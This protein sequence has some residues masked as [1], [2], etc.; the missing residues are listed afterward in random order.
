MANS[1]SQALKEAQDKQ[2]ESKVNRRASKA[3]QDLEGH[4]HVIRS[5]SESPV[6][7]AFNQVQKKSRL[8][9]VN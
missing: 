5:G 1:L 2:F 3:A 6:V 7:Q 9:K 4:V 8:R